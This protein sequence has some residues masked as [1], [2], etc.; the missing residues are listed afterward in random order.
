MTLTGIGVALHIYVIMQRTPIDTAAFRAHRVT[1]SPTIGGSVMATKSTLV[2]TAIATVFLML[3]P[4]MP[5]AQDDNGSA[6][7]A[8][9]EGD[10]YDYKDHQPTAPTPSTATGNPS[11]GRYLASR[12]TTGY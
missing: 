1:R 2:A 7:V 11:S 4:P 9:R 10:T 3:S 6:L 5:A 8:P 12:R